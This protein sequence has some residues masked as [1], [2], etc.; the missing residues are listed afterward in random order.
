GCHGD[1]PAAGGPPEVL[2]ATVVTKRITEWDE[3]TGRFEAVDSV[4]VRPRASGYI[5]EGKFRESPILAKDQVLV[6]LDP[7]QYQADLDRAHAGVELAKSQYELANIEAVRA[8]KLKVSGAVSREELDQRL[9]LRNQQQA[10]IAAANAAR[11][12]AELLLSFTQ[13][14]APV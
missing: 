3:Y 12:S 6:V 13:V 2:T 10:N 1:A 14:R 5:G 11:Y 7:R 4:A 9:S 8:E